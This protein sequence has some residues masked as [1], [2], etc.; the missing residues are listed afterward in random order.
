M[1]VRIGIITRNRCS[2]LQKA[3]ESALRQD[4]PRKEIAVHDIASTD[5]TPALRKNYPEVIWKR[6]ET[7]LEMI[8]PRNDLMRN[9][10]AEFYFTLDDDAWFLAPDSLTRGIDWMRQNPKVAVLA[11][12][13]LLPGEPVRK[14][15]GEPSETNVFIACGALLQ[16]SALERVG[17]YDACP[18]IYGGGEE[19]D[20]CLRLMEAGY[21]IQI[22]PG[23]HIWHER[24]Q[25]GRDSHDQHRSAV[26][27]Q[28]AYIVLRCPGSL[29]WVYLP[30]KILRH[31][32]NAIT[33]G[34]LKSYTQGIVMF[35]KSISALI[36]ARA[37]VSR[38]TY[39]RSLRL[40][41]SK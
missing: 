17:Y 33:T 10:D 23:L 18:A 38:Q 26:C 30:W 9:T 16:R 34:R 24:T 22:W 25:T 5:N 39:L 28:M 27:N 20:L 15:L 41:R 21:I 4:Y 40:N 36:R 13:V 2:V 31:F 14:E 6:S 7:R 32:I 37:P 11:Y 19:T 29:L 35:L 12:D 3:L 1:K 8:A